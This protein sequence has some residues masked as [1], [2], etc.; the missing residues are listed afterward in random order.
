MLDADEEHNVGTT[1]DALIASLID[2]DDDDDQNG[3]EERGGKGK[4]H[5]GRK[6]GE[7]T[8]REKKRKRK[9]L[10]WMKEERGA[11]AAPSYLISQIRPIPLVACG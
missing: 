2:E 1:A 9:T 3:D 11:A 6:E 4:G 5:K 10:S 8:R 7:R